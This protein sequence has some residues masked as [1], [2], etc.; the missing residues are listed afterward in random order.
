MRARR[1]CLASAAQWFVC[2]AFVCFTAPPRG[3]PSCSKIGGRRRD[4]TKSTSPSMRRG[5][6]LLRFCLCRGAAAAAA[7][8][9]GRRV[10]RVRMACDWAM[11]RLRKIYWKKD[12]AEAA[13][14]L[15]ENARSV[16][17]SARAFKRRLDVVIGMQRGGEHNTRLQWAQH[18]MERW[19]RWDNAWRGFEARRGATQRWGTRRRIRCR[20]RSRP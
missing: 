16:T 20:R 3:T 5:G 6:D 7:R 18:I 2:D 17:K 15:L 13:C 10:A 12:G 8:G 1:R 4:E 9:R 19:G 11:G 14:L